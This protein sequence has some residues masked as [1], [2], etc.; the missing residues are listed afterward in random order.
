[1]AALESIDHSAALES[2]SSIGGFLNRVADIL[3]NMVHSAKTAFKTFKTDKYDLKP[4]NFN[5][6]IL[7]KTTKGSKYLVVSDFKVYV[8]QGFSGNLKD[9]SIALGGAMD[10]ANGIMER[11]TLFNSLLSR[12][13]S[14]KDTRSSVRNLAIATSEQSKLR[15]EAVS[16]LKPFKDIDNRRTDAK[17]GEVYRSMSEIYE[18]A[19]LTDALI[20]D[21][22]A[23]Q[24]GN[25]NK[26]VEEA[27]E[28]LDT[29][30]AAAQNGQLS[31]LTPEALKS[32]ASSTLT[33]ARD[34]EMYALLMNE[35]FSM[36]V[37]VQDT[38]KDMIK[39]LRY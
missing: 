27:G 13:I 2:F 15:D 5:T 3:P 37:A 11:L 23:L 19:L 22:S 7:E 30:S 31:G 32:V 10:Y 6:T 35:V 4:L 34:V 39:Q 9:Y 29:L 16:A 12:I 26:L 17:L 25:I 8:P 36:K 14:D 18:V 24:M 20:S 33:A 1:M 28:L 21:A 38:A